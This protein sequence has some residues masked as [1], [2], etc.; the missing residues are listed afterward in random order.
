[1][2]LKLG[3]LP[4][5]YDRR[6]IRLSQI[7]NPLPPPPD[8]YSVDMHLPVQI[9]VS[10]LGNDEW[11]DC[12]QVGE[13]N[14]L[15]RFECLEQSVC[16][17]ITT[18]DVLN[19]YWRKQGY[20]ANKC[21]LLNLINRINGDTNPDNGLVVLD[22]LKSWRNEGWNL[23]GYNY[24]IH[25]FASALV[26]VE[27]KRCIQYLG[28]AQVGLAVPTNMIPQF[29]AGEPWTVDPSS[30]FT[31]EGHL[32]YAGMYDQDWLEC[33]TWGRKQ[34]MSWEFFRKYRDE[35][36]GVIDERDLWKPDSPIDPDALEALL[37]QI[38]AQVI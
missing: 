8:T 37:T 27:V 17:P 22:S 23:G 29:N 11:G 34:L 19:E 10:M 6:T 7:L 38:I 25:A 24:K 5:R 20:A 32:V 3:K 12:V 21:W 31:G 13:T 15:L 1:M 9:P 35:S 2:S 36:Y 26:D 33:I 18:D 28:G 16:V 30:S 14:Q 4:A